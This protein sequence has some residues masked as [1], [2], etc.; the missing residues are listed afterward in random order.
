[1]LL[2]SPR[3][4]TFKQISGVC[5][6]YCRFFPPVY[7][8]TYRSVSLIIMACLL[9][10]LIDGNEINTSGCGEFSRFCFLELISL[11]YPVDQTLVGFN[12]VV[13]AIIML[14]LKFSS[15]DLQ[16]LLLFPTAAHSGVNLA[17]EFHL[18]DTTPYF[19][20]ISLSSTTSYELMQFTV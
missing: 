2:V 3:F 1:M 14:K 5:K 20:Y 4:A 18:L 17:V 16:Y 19:T 15:T 12:S 13:Y 8:G 6:T 11:S 10:L 9:F 7:E